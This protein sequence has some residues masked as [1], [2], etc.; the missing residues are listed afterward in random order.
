MAR[1]ESSTSRLA[2]LGASYT[3]L[4]LLGMTMALPFVWTLL[5]SLKQ[6]VEVFTG[7]MP[8]DPSMANYGRVFDALPFG[9]FYLNTALVTVARVFLTVLSC[10]L[11][12]YGFARLRAPGK[13]FL[14]MLLLGTMMLPWAARPRMA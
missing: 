4:L 12:A 13:N 1:S 6:E 8:S 10:S 14:F 7:W 11:V 2:R 5:T 9:R 3:V